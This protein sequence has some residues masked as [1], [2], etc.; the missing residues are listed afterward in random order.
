MRARISCLFAIV[1]WLIAG[2]AA[3]IHNA[4]RVGNPQ[5]AP[6]SLVLIWSAAKAPTQSNLPAL[7]AALIGTPGSSYWTN[8]DSEFGAL[9]S[10]LGEQLLALGVPRSAEVVSLD[11]RHNKAQLDAAIAAVGP[12][13]AAIVMYPEAVTSYCTAGCYAFR[14]RVNYISPMSHRLVW[15]GVVDLPPKV[16]HRDPFGP[17]ALDFLATLNEQ[18]DKEG[19]LPAAVGAAAPAADQRSSSS[20]QPE[21]RKQVP[22]SSSFALRDDPTKVPV[23]PEGRDRFVHYLTLP[24]PK[25][26]AIS[27]TGGWRYFSGDPDAMTKALNRCARDGATCWLYAVDDQVVWSAAPEK[28]IGI[29]Q[30]FDR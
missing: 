24:T 10:A 13:S 23:R 11:A 17:R 12:E 15:T 1:T 29:G 19:L 9:G 5:S 27:A 16:N 30:L 25:A 8:Y 21:H 2:C 22:P 14:I 28:R 26:F 20:A 18:L 4:K 3:T 6:Q 7:G